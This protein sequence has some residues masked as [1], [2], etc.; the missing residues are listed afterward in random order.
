MVE[1]AVWIKLHFIFTWEDL[2][3]LQFATTAAS[4]AVPS[5]YL[6]T[7]LAGSGLVPKEEL[8]WV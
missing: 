3:A 1:V 6:P 7:P 4:Q 8:L 2:A 5:R